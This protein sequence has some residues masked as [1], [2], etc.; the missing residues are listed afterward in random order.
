MRS[1]ALIFTIGGRAA[2]AIV[3]AGG[4]WFI[5]ATSIQEAAHAGR[6]SPNVA[7]VGFLVGV[8]AI[9]VPATKAAAIAPTTTNLVFIV[10]LQKCA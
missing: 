4:L 10:L 7:F 1:R 2:A 5:P 8:C 3:A 6:V 9:A